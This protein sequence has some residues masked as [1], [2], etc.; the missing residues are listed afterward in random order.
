M[1]LA[2]S[3]LAAGRVWTLEEL[4]TIIETTMSSAIGGYDMPMRVNKNDPTMGGRNRVWAKKHRATRRGI[5][6]NKE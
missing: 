5:E 4:D 6:L 1:T 2:E 3:L